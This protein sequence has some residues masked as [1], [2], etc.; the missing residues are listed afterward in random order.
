MYT[1]THTH[2]HIYIYI[3]IYIYTHSSQHRDAGRAKEIQHLETTVNVACQGNLSACQ[4]FTSP[5]LGANGSFSN[6]NCNI[7]HNSTPCLHSV[8]MCFI[9]MSKQTAVM[10]VVTGFG[11]RD[12]AYLLCGLK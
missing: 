6:T 4:R 7:Q 10:S 5:A 1:H 8:F 11:N 12:G 2:T 9:C 3:Y